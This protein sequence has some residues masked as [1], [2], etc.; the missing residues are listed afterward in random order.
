[1]VD[2]N[3]DAIKLLKKKF[4]KSKVV[5]SD[6]FSKVPKTQKFDLI[7]F[8]PPYLPNNSFDKQPDT[9][10]GKN[11]SEI[12]NKFLKSAKKYLSKKGKIFL[13]TSSFTKEIDWQDYEKKLLGENRVFFEEIYVWELS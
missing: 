6:L 8:N 10:G 4:S 9:S 1:M 5:L 3:P 7:I 2:I 11:G 13:I 12:I